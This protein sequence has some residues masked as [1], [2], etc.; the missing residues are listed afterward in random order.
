M[1][2]DGVMFRSV[3]GKARRASA[4]AALMAAC[5]G[6]MTSLTDVHAADKLSGDVNIDSSSTVAPITMAAAE[7]FQGE[8]PRVR[9]T[10]EISGTGGGFKKFLDERADLRTDI[11]DASRP[12][13][14]HD[15]ARVEEIGAEFIEVAIAIDGIAVVVHPSNDFCDY[16][17]VAEL[18]KIW[19]CGSAETRPKPSFRRWV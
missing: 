13:K 10:V 7:L 6:L 14:D 19:E 8:L 15:L 4:V 5:F 11:S 2:I 1:Q 3:R 9:V 16:L 18:K 12:I 17:T